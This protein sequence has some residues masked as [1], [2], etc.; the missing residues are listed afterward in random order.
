MRVENFWD[1][2]Y[3]SSKN[4]NEI[5]SW[6]EDHL[7]EIPQE[8]NF[9]ALDLGCGQGLD[10]MFLQKIGF[11][12]IAADLSSVALKLLKCKNEKIGL[13]QLDHSKLLPFK[14]NSFE[15]INANLSLHYFEIEDTVKIIREVRRCLS[16]TGT[17]FTRF[18]S[19]ND[20]NCGAVDENKIFGN[21]YKVDGQNKS[22]FSQED[23]IKLFIDWN[24]KSIQEK[25][26]EYYG[27]EKVLWEIIAE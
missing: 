23:L 7:T 22:F 10:S 3:S 2:I 12:V 25:T 17:F 16:T 4:A 13:I 18:N 5:N 8:K 24:I 26:I 27:R 6:L 19:I 1:K 15:M 14:E 21:L 11:G 20:K 9:A